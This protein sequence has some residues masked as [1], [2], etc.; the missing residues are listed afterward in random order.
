MKC[1]YTDATQSSPVVV[2]QTGSNQIADVAAV[3]A[4][5]AAAAASDVAATA[6]AAAVVIVFADWIDWRTKTQGNYASNIA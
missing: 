5:A 3:V 4:A 2:T 1:D 6:A